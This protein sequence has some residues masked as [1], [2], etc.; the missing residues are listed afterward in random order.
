[1]IRATIVL[2]TLLGGCLQKADLPIDC[3][4]AGAQGW[5]HCRSADFGGDFPAAPTAQ[6]AGAAGSGVLVW[7]SQGGDATY[8]VSVLPAQN[9]S[10]SGD[11]WLKDALSFKYDVVAERNV[12][13]KFGRALDYDVKRDARVGR[14]RIIDQPSQKRR[15]MLQVDAPSA[16]QVANNFFDNFA[17][18]P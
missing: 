14:I 11:K 13:T 6:Q 10:E 5:V 12:E 2:S 7:T 16:D 8:T 17:P 9:P 15:F 3:Q 4:P 18:I 1:M